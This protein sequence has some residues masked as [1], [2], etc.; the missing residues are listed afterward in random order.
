MAAHPLN[1]IILPVLSSC[2]DNA[3]AFGIDAAS[4]DVERAQA[5]LTV[6]RA[7]VLREVD[8]AWRDYEKARMQ[9]ERYAKD[10]RPVAQDA[11][12]LAL[13]SY[14]AGETALL[15]LLDA[16]RTAQGIESSLLDAIRQ[17]HAARVRLDLAT[18]SIA[19]TSTGTT[20]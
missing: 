14:Q 16:R 19:D 9:V 20:P 17:A 5:D 7:K 18:G 2:D 10:L 1:G 4:A 12:R 6:L 3:H 13:G 8:A 15:D 11:L